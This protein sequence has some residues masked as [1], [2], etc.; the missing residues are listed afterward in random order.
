MQAL[1]ISITIYTCIILLTPETW[2][3]CA[4]NQ[5]IDQIANFLVQSPIH[6]PSKLASSILFPIK[7]FK[8]ILLDQFSAQCDLALRLCNGF[9]YS[10]WNFSRR[11]MSVFPNWNAKLCSVSGRRTHV[12]L[13]FESELKLHRSPLCSNACS[14]FGWGGPPNVW[15][16][17]RFLVGEQNF[18]I[19]QSPKILSNFSKKCIKINKNLKNYGKIREKY[20]TFW[21]KF[22]F[23][24]DLNFFNMGRL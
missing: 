12:K 18:I 14:S 16:R 6:C 24:A 22:K 23:R 10:N 9:L 21:E 7:L 3:N 19:G 1:Y 4:N 5:F 2:Q 8:S 11:Q 17:V 15:A 13:N 20:K